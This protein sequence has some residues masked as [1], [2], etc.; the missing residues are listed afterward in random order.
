MARR[1]HKPAAALKAAASQ[2]AP[3]SPSVDAALGES[4]AGSEAAASSNGDPDTNTAGE[5]GDTIVAGDGVDS[6][7]GGLAEDSIEGGGN[8]TLIGGGNLDEEA[9]ADMAAAHHDQVVST[10]EVISLT[11]Q[12]S[13]SSA[14]QVSDLASVIEPVETP[15]AEAF[16]GSS[17][18]PAVIDLGMDVTITLGDLVTAT[19]HRFEIDVERWN[20]LS[21][22]IRDDFLAAFQDDLA[23]CI[24]WPGYSRVFVEV[25]SRD[26]QPYRRCGLVWTGQPQVF[27]VHQLVA[28]RLQA[29][30]FLIVRPAPEPD[31]D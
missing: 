28:E 14:P 31:Q 8:D 17:K 19:V 10:G 2:T 11:T 25:V 12:P 18:L 5:G 21:D 13:A 3:T 24:R 15:A 1:S 23:E 26:G 29:D 7:E 16:V 30:P 6:I 22:D 20:A 27:G 4:G 9:F